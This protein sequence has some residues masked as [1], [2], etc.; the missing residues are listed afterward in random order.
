MRGDIAD[1][2]VIVMAGSRGR[3]IYEGEIQHVNVRFPK[4]VYDE[5]SLLAN[6]NKKS[7][8]QYL[9]EICEKATQGMEDVV[10][11][12]EHMRFRRKRK[13]YEGEIVRLS[14]RFPKK[15]Y[16]KVTI[17]AYKEEKSINQ[18]LVNLCEQ[19][20]KEKEKVLSAYKEIRK[21]LSD[22]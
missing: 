9:V 16:A 21:A 8:N 20:V 1:G 13:L 12:I 15:T 14:L 2:K 18:Y 4:S 11:E 17:L 6:L 10:G 7:T 22:L 3:R 5:L 19:E